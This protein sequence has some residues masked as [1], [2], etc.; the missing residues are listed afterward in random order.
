MR[1]QERGSSAAA[2]PFDSRA[3][4]EHRDAA[5][6]ERIFRAALGH[7]QGRAMIPLQILGV[8]GQGADQEDRVPSSNAT[9]TKEP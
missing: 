1:C 8:F 7:Q 5:V 9:V 6:R 3:Q 2:I 4:T